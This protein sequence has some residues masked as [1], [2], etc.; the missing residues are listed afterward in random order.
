MSAIT[1]QKT[2][3]EL[4]AQRTPANARADLE[5]TSASETNSS[6]AS[7]SGALSN[8]TL[9]TT[10][11]SISGGL[12]NRLTTVENNYVNK[13]GDV[14]TGEL[15]VISGAVHTPSIYFSGDTNTGIYSSGSDVINM[16]RNG[17]KSFEINFSGVAIGAGATTNATPQA[18]GEVAI[19]HN[20]STSDGGSIAIGDTATIGV[21]KWES[22]AIGSNATSTGQYGVAIGRGATASSHQ[23]VIGGVDTGGN[24]AYYTDF[25]FG[26]SEY[27]TRSLGGIPVTLHSAGIQGTNKTASD[28]SIAGGRSTGNVDGGSVTI[29]TA[30]ASDTSSASPNYLEDRFRIYGNGNLYIGETMTSNGNR[31]TIKDAKTAVTGSLAGSALSI[32]QSWNTAG[33][34]TAIKLNVTN[35]DS[36]VNS[37]LIDLQIGTVSKFKIDKSG[38]VTI[39]GSMTVG[40]ISSP[41]VGLYTEAF[42]ESA[43]ANNTSSGIWNSAFGYNALSTNTNGLNNTAVGGFAL[44]K[45]TLGNYNTALGTY[46][47][48]SNTIGSQN[49]AFGSGA[50]NANIS[51]GQ[52]CAFGYDALKNNTYGYGNLAFGLDACLENTTGY[53][54]VAIGFAALQTNTTGS[55]NIAIGENAGAYETGSDKLYI[56]GSAG[57]S[58]DALIYGDFVTGELFNRGKLISKLTPLAFTPTPT[59]SGVKG[60]LGIYSGYLYMWKE[61]A[62]VVRVAVETTW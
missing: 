38:I 52:N 22:I 27:V 44:W 41:K 25:F 60:S 57:T 30:P 28:L 20:A 54:N 26:G 10:T 9:L 21:G 18:T 33:N 46:A 53:S 61:S 62:E 6:I 58:G 2:F 40:S 35:V 13:T 7:I 45:N 12:N 39:P 49:C 19:G 59:T 55:R 17:E 14:M 15:G 24:D 16:T 51:G 37:N 29:Q 1:R 11:E 36:G 4:V 56:T 23:V 47:L 3:P 5:V 8:Y 34:P 42:G 32:L 43:L 50:L 31:V 48:D